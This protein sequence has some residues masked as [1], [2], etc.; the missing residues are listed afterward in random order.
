MA[1]ILMLPRNHCK[2]L[3]I[4]FLPEFF[5]QPGGF[6]QSKMLTSLLLLE[7][8][9]VAVAS[10]VSCSTWRSSAATSGRKTRV[11]KSKK[12]HKNHRIQFIRTTFRITNIYIY[13]KHVFVCDVIH[14]IYAIYISC[15][16]IL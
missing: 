2:N 1:T 9:V 4:C 10:E 11:V 13:S 6:H 8:T 15:F 5:T 14:A 3:G 12:K 16:V 7:A